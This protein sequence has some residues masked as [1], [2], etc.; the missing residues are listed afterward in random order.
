MVG[1]SV[2]KQ[3]DQGRVASL[4]DPPCLLVGVQY[5]Y[6]HRY[7]LVHGSLL[8]SVYLFDTFGHNP[9]VFNLIP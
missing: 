9:R 6:Y 1:K 2:H 5:E 7:K 4:S 8:L 3:V